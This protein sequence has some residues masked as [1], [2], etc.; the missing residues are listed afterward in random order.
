[1]SNAMDLRPDAAPAPEAPVDLL[2]E[3]L[4]ELR[5]IHATLA[6]QLHDKLALGAPELAA[7]LG[8]SERTVW[9]VSS[10]GE[11]PSPFRL[12]ARTLWDVAELRMW[13]ESGRPRREE[14][15]RMRHR[16]K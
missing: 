1:M 10:A 9:S 8:V 11:I 14:W 13:M 3:V 12:G 16:R 6:S 4:A 2:A 5:A 7:A 15:E